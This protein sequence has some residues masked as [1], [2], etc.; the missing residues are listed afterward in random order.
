LGVPL[1][2]ITFTSS[3]IKKT[4]QKDV[5]YVDLF[6]I[7]GDVQVAFGIITCCFVQRPCIF[8]NAHLHLPPSYTPLFLLT[9]PAIKCL[10]TFWVQDPLIALKDL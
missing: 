3:F 2:T 7:M 6:P 9:P 4:L 5:R 8:Y 10:N 1:G